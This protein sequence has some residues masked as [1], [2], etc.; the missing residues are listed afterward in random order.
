MF[1]TFKIQVIQHG[2]N[3]TYMPRNQ[4]KLMCDQ[5]VNKGQATIYDHNLLIL[6]L[7]RQQAQSSYN[8][9]FS[10]AIRLA[11]NELVEQ[12]NHKYGVTE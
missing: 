12:K 7:L 11:S 2:S 1:S 8:E 3:Q 5:R 6:E 9:G 4:L 10:E